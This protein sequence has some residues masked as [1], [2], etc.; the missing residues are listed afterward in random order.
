MNVSNLELILVQKISNS[1][2]TLDTLIYSKALQ[3]LKTG[4]VTVVNTTADLPNPNTAF[5]GHLF[6]EKTT[7]AMYLI[8]ELGY[9]RRITSET[10]NIN[11]WGANN[12]GQLGNGNLPVARCSPSSVSGGGNNWWKISSGYSSVLAIKTN[13][14]LWAWGSN[15]CG[16]LGI[17]TTFS[18]SSPVLVISNVN[19]WI[20]VS[21]A[22]DSSGG[23]KADG[24]LWTWGS[25]QNGVLGDGTTT[26]KSSPDQVAG[27]GTT[28]CA[29]S[30][31]ASSAAIKTDGTLW[32][33]GFNASFNG[34][35]ALGDGTTT[36]RNSPG[37]TAGGGTNWRTVSV[38]SGH[39]GAIKTDGTLWTWGCNTYG[40]LGIGNTT[41]TCSPATVAGGG[42]N[43]CAISAGNNFT[44]AIKTDGTLWTWGENGAGRLG[45]GTVSSRTSPGTVAGGGTTWSRIC[46]GCLHTAAIKTDGTLWTWGGNTCGQLG[47][48]T[49]TSRNSPVTTVA[50]GTNW[51]NVSTSNNGTVAICAIRGG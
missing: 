18:K 22:G 43:W 40:Q 35:G 12:A 6:Y 42:T 23:I 1:T 8:D 34:G 19:N 31:R 16:Q 50:G 38:G 25:N 13:G 28:W 11:T 45:D 17:E 7:E 37:T 27:G 49:I 4:T 3:E 36:A 51:T 29:L 24:T 30:M 20:E 44:A 9:A 15:C 48:G 5:V 41:N 32:T 33:W 21:S 39:M 10:D 26:N 2:S 46:A 14:S 47:D